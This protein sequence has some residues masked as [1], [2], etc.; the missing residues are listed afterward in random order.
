LATSK[1]LLPYTAVC[2]NTPI[3]SIDFLNFG[4]DDPEHKPARQGDTKERIICSS[5]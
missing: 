2:K 3:N 1:R 5:K 4:Q